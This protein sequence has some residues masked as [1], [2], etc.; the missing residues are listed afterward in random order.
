MSETT[1]K[2]TPSGSDSA[3]HGVVPAGISGDPGPTTEE[4]RQTRRLVSA[5]VLMASGTALSRVMGFFRL[6]LLVYLF[7]GRYFLRGLTAGAVK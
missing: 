7:G 5:G 4:R 1:P 3:G 2:I 6:M